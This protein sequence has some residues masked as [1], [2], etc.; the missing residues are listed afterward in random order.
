[1][2]RAIRK[3]APPLAAAA[4][5]AGAPAP[6]EA[7]PTVERSYAGARTV[8]PAQLAARTLYLNLRGRPRGVSATRLRALV[9]RSAAYWGIQTAGT[10]RTPGRLDRFDVIGFS[11][12]TPAFAAGAT[13][14]STT[15]NG[16]LVRREFDVFLNPRL[17]WAAGPARPSRRQWDLESVILHEIGHVVGARH[18]SRCVNSPMYHSITNGEW[19]RAEDNWFRWGCSN[20]PAGPPR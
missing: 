7:T 8:A 4:L 6:A 19:W 16:G 10:S 1:M 11:R 15:R 3:L 2:S 12:R 14:I 5:L 17:P 9:R 13:L 18:T 20:A